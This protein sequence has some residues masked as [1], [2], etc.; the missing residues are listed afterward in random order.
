M[1]ET[2]STLPKRSLFATLLAAA[3]LL[4]AAPPAVA[5]ADPV[6]SCP[7]LNDPRL[8][9]PGRMFWCPDTHR[10]VTWLQYCS[11]LTQ[12]P[13]LPGGRTPDGG[14]AQ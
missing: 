9:N 4:G 8:C 11:S 3:G 2:T 7:G 5:H 14:L 13:Y 12:G 1:S 10:M 6:P